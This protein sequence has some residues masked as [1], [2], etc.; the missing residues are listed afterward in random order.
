MGFETQLTK[1][2]S[3]KES[4]FFK[5]FTEKTDSFDC[6]RDIATQIS[7]AVKYCALGRA[8]DIYL[9]NIVILLRPKSTHERMIK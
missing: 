3:I 5:F 2:T 7:S 8:R 6:N 4:D 1:L 9:S